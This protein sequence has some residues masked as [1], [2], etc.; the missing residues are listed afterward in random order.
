[1]KSLIVKLTA[2]LVMIS[3]ICL[4]AFS[5]AQAAP[6]YRWCNKMSDMLQSY[7]ASN[8]NSDVESYFLKQADLRDA[9]DREDKAALAA[10]ITEVIRMVGRSDM[11]HD[12]A[13]ELINYLYVWRSKV[14]TPGKYTKFAHSK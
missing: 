4:L 7:Q 2:V 11:D 12:S 8:P 10:G 3:S 1:M 13:V 5:A 9:T 14:T 6:D